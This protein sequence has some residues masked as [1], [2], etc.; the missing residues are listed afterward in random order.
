[1]AIAFSADRTPTWVWIPKMAILPGRPLHLVD[2]PVVA[3]VGGDVLDGPVGERVGAG[4]QQRQAQLLGHRHH[5]RQRSLE[6]GPGLGHGRADPGDDL[7]VRFHELVLGL[8]M[9]LAVLVLEAF[10]DRLPPLRNSREARSTSCSSTSIPRLEPA[11]ALNKMSTGRAYQARVRAETRW[12]SSRRNNWVT[13]EKH[14]VVSLTRDKP[15]RGRVGVEGNT[16]WVLAS[17]ALVLFMTPGLAFFYGGM[18]RSQE[19]AR[20]AHAELLR[21]GPRQ[22]AVGAW[23]ASASPSATAAKFIG[24]FDFVGLK[25][26]RP[27]PSSPLPGYVRRL[28]PDHPAAGVL[29]LPDDVRHHHAGA[30][31]RRHRRPAEVP[32][33]RACSSA[34]WSLLVYAPVA[35]WVFSPTGWLFERG[36]LDFAGGTVVHINAGIAALAVDPRGRQAQGLARRGRCR[37]TPCR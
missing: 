36:A 6:V 18:V 28:R 35:H 17:A 5:L 27:T 33:L 26:H 22:R 13:A 37:R 14:A 34:L 12:V 7:D 25:R 4:A 16:A 23:S 15:T 29:R 3:L 30:D 32:G 11:E 19:R 10:E 8:R 21:H 20:H 9:G 24:N 31:H 2:Q 1:M